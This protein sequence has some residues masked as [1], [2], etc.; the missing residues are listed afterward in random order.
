MLNQGSHS[1]MTE[2]WPFPINGGDDPVSGGE[3]EIRRGHFGQGLGQFVG[4][5]INDAS[6]DESI[7]FEQRWNSHNSGKKRYDAL[8]GN[9]S[10]KVVSPSATSGMVTFFVLDIAQR[11]YF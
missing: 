8:S 3:Y 10:A 5:P 7:V 4:N 2:I 11:C 6:G 9:E 1:N